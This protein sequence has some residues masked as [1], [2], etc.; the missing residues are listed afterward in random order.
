LWF[1]TTALMWQWQEG[2]QSF[3]NH[4]REYKQQ[5]GERRPFL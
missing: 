5:T 1:K 4:R 3:I 2:F